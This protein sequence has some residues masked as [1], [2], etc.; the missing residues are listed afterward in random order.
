MADGSFGGSGEDQLRV[1]DASCVSEDAK[2]R[3]TCLIDFRSG[4]Q[5]AYTVTVS[6]SGTW[7]AR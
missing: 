6:E 7:V 2:K 1:T 3:Y 5:Q 4:Y